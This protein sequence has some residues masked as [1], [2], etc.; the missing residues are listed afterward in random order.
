MRTALQYVSLLRVPIF[1]FAVGVA[2]SW[3][4]KGV[5][6]LL[7]G[8][9]DVKLAAVPIVILAA[10]V[11]SATLSLCAVAI[12]EGAPARTGIPAP[13]GWFAQTMTVSF[14]AWREIP[15]KNIWLVFGGLALIP[16]LLCPVRL[17]WASDRH[18]GLRTMVCLGAL[19]ACVLLSFAC[20]PVYWGY[21]ASARAMASVFRFDPRGY[22]D[23]E[24]ERLGQFHVY[25]AHCVFVIFAQLALYLAI[26]QV[27]LRRGK[28]VPKWLL[29]W[30][31]F[32]VLYSVY[33]MLGLLCLLLSALGFFLDG[34]GLSLLLVLVLWRFLAWY[35]DPGNTVGFYKPVI[36]LPSP[37]EILNANSAETG[38]RVIVVC[39]SGGGIHAA[40]WTAR[41]PDGTR[42]AAPREFRGD[43]AGDLSRVGR[44]CWGHELRGCL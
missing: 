15:L 30:D 27:Q 7:R 24:A 44:Q 34:Y 18:R 35:L 9:F 37:R 2:L 1:F 36:E 13:G 17:I 40:A 11:Y 28:T 31:N 8:T 25:A 6:S 41:V 39:A 5:R 21:D 20:S 42:S 26:V 43:G 4:P 38:G 16:A 29:R 10:L 32:P 23:P 22:I 3:H 14:L 33:S 12:L 19:A